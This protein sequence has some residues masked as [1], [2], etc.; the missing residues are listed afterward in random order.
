MHAM[1]G[2]ACFC[3]FLFGRLFVLLDWF[4]SL[5][6]C[7]AGCLLRRRRRCSGSDTSWTNSRVYVR[8][9][10]P[11]YQDIRLCASRRKQFNKIC[12]MKYL[13]GKTQNKII[14]VLFREKVN[15]LRNRWSLICSQLT[16]FFSWCGWEHL[17]SF[18]FI[19]VVFCYKC[20]SLWGVFIQKSA[21]LALLEHISLL[22]TQKYFSLL[23]IR[24]TIMIDIKSKPQRFKFNW[25][26]INDLLCFLHN[27]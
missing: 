8:Q 27:I 13:P 7:F 18:L 5:V 10:C 23:I 4:A 22:L 14:V 3:F 17:D 15:L 12:Q 21:T 6:G 20:E 26:I 24:T 19:I 2:F 16:R 25:R 9:L 1:F 11:E